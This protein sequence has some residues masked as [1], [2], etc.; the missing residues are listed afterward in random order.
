MTAAQQADQE[1]ILRNFIIS[2]LLL[3][4]V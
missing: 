2:T 3:T 1:S 4:L